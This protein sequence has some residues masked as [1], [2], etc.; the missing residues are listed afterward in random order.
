MRNQ[1][2][3]KAIQYMGACNCMTPKSVEEWP[4]WVNYKSLNK[5]LNALTDEELEVFVDGEIKETANLVARHGLHEANCFFD[6]V[7]DGDLNG[8]FFS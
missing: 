4:S 6:L 8:Y 2:I 1:T 7:F 5:Q 3:V